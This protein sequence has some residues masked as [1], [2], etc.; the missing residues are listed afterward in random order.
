[1]FFCDRKYL[2]FPRSGKRRKGDIG[3]KGGG[4]ALDL[5]LPVVVDPVVVEVRRVAMFKWNGWR[6][7][8]G[9]LRR[10]G[11]TPVK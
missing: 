10:R 6:G 1:M 7:R 5:L 2:S 11:L 4:D 8:D 9:D 3:G